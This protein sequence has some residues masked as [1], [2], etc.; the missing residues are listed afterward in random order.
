MIYRKLYN[1]T[2]GLARDI[3]GINVRCCLTSERG[4]QMIYQVRRCLWL[5]FIHMFIS[6]FTFGGG[7]VVI[8]MI[9]KYFVEKHALFQ[10]EDLLEMSAV[11]QSAPGAIA[12]NL[13]ALTG[14][15]VAGRI[16]ALRSCV[17][18]VVPPLLILSLVS[19]GYEAVAGNRILRGILGGMETGVAALIVDLLIDMWRALWR[20]KYMLLPILAVGTFLGSY[21]LHLPVLLLL[22]LSSFLCAAKMWGRRGGEVC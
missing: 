12:V 6:A 10:E 3:I 21:V 1:F 13:S 18:S 16:G 9:R 15:R 2:N 5:F 8:P 19:M 14:Y 22:G 4:N 20:E 17:G 11:A 7:Y